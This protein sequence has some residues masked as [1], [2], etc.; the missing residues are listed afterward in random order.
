MIASNFNLLI[1]QFVIVNSKSPLNSNLQVYYVNERTDL[2]SSY[3]DEKTNLKSI[4]G[5]NKYPTGKNFAE[6]I[7]LPDF[8]LA[9]NNDGTITVNNV[10]Y[11][12]TKS[13][14]GSIAQ[15]SEDFNNLPNGLTFVS[16]GQN[17]APE[18]TSAYWVRTFNSS[19]YNGRKLQVSQSDSSNNRYI[20]IYNGSWNNWDSLATGSEL[21]NG[22]ANKVTDNKNGS[23]EVNGSSITPADNN[24]IN[25]ELNNKVT[26]NK[27]GSITVN[28]SSITP[29]DNN[30]VNTE[31]NNKVTDN[32]DGSI[33]VNGAT[34]IPVSSSG[35][36][37][38]SGI[39]NFTGSIQHNGNSVGAH[40]Q[41]SNNDKDSAISDST[42]GNPDDIYYWLEN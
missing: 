17:N 4:F 8:K 38:L 33:T 2:M 6:L 19:A 15:I 11:D 30:T 31:L 3:D 40:I 41:A 35:N 14:L 34:F 10:T 16:V 7:N 13:D 32:K 12:M 26:D 23:I 25:A 37:T 42:K 24:T 22:L 27:N 1:I 18:P 9:E 21:N 39:N 29:A 28:G 36:N 5:D 20:R